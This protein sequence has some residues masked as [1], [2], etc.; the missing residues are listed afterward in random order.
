LQTNC[1]S[2]AS[3]P[4]IPLFFLGTKDHKLCCGEAATCGLGEDDERDPISFSSGSWALPG[5]AFFPLPDS[6]PWLLQHT[7]ERRG[8]KRRGD[9]VEIHRPSSL[10]RWRGCGSKQQWIVSGGRVVGREVRVRL[11]SRS[12]VIRVV[13]SEGWLGRGRKRRDSAGR[14]G[15]THCGVKGRRDREQTEGGVLGESGMEGGQSK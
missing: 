10:L 11:R 13:G 15:R 9:G 4:T 6:P 7:S 14:R 3:T 12:G 8:C 2:H 1:C 5:V